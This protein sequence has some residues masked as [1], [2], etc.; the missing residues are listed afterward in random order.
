LPK[1]PLINIEFSILAFVLLLLCG[2]IQTLHNTSTLQNE[3]SA[4]F[5]TDAVA[6]S[7]TAEKKDYI[8]QKPEI[9][10]PD[11]TPDKTD[12]TGINTIKV[13]TTNDTENHGI[14]ADENLSAQK[15]IQSVLDEALDFCQVSQE[16]WQKGELENAIEALDKAYSLI[17]DVNTNDD[18]ELVQQ[19]EDLRFMISKRILEIYASRNIVVNGNHNAIPMV[20]NKHIQAEIILFTKGNEKNF[21][22]ESY[23]RSGMYR[24]YMVEALK[25]A[26]LPVE[27]SW[28]P[29]IES[30]FKVDAFSKARALG[31]WQ[32]IPST[33]Y[34]FGL[35]R[36]I[37]IDERM[38]PFKATRAAIAY[39]KELHSIFG[40]WATVLAAYNCGEG[41]VLR[42]IRSQ[43]VN[44]LDNFW[45]LYERLPRETARYVPRFLAVL[46]ILKD[47]EKNR[48]DP[49]DTPLEYETIAVTKQVYLKDIAKKI[50][51]SEKILSQLNPELRY[52]MLPGDEY[53]LKVPKDKGSVLL[54]S[55]DDIPVSSPP[56]PAYVNHKVKTGETLSTI[57]RKYQTSMSKI[58]MANNIRKQNYIVAGTILKIPQKG[59][60][61]PKPERYNKSKYRQVTT[62]VVKSGDSLWIIAR[63]Y[64]TTTQKIQEISKLSSTNLYIGQV[65]K[66]PGSDIENASGKSLGTYMVKR[67]DSPF[68]IA[69]LHNMSL[70][71]FLRINR[72]TPRSKIYPGQKL[73][74]E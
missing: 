74:I 5:K 20:M 67:G 51:S 66:I 73:Y 12:D 59:T 31:L 15:K 32:F 65:L 39:L 60:F 25:E 19:K 2:C 33:G 4:C 36:D 11:K 50:G 58:A 62:H 63:R 7:E 53:P 17:L 49:V 45:D 71:H 52:K 57:A 69:R 6:S 29:L 3:N 1:K 24:P 26:G 47:M 38:D 10:N 23:K 37:F 44:Y 72:L 22:I 21:F 14:K 30:G 18:S 13:S 34:K 48:F 16:F 40:D 68:S 27:L 28:L 46:H 8:N 64:S 55:L 35:K 54:T 70:E 43:N 61:V 56:R 42:V 41:K 9:F